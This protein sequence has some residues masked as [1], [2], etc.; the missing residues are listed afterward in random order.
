MTTSQAAIRRGGLAPNQLAVQN[1][2]AG[3]GIRTLDVNLG[4]VN[5]GL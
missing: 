1:L 5:A 4:K 2:G 3:A